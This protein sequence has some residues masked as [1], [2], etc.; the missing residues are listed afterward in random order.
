MCL[1]SFLNYTIGHFKLTLSRH[2]AWLDPN[3]LQILKCQSLNVL[4]ISWRPTLSLERSE[5]KDGSHHVCG[6]WLSRWRKGQ[7]RESVTH[8]GMME[9]F[10][11]LNKQPLGSWTHLSGLLLLFL[12]TKLTIQPHP[13]RQA[14][15]SWSMTANKANCSSRVNPITVTFSHN[16][17]QRVKFIIFISPILHIISGV[18]QKFSFSRNYSW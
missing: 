17:F 18:E 6:L 4:W 3:Y 16:I 14:G 11:A 8:E 9:R 7:S 10:A 1:D 2:L 5:G 13:S 15:P 12:N